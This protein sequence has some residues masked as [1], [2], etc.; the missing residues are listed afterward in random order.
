[1]VKSFIDIKTIL[2]NNYMKLTPLINAF[3][4]I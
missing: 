1:M 4:M 2:K 3:G